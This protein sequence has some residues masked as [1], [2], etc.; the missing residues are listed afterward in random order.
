MKGII[1]CHSNTTNLALFG[2]KIALHRFN[3]RGL[4]LIIQRILKFNVNFYV[5]EPVRR[6]R[7]SRAAPILW[8]FCHGE[9]SSV[10]LSSPRLTW[11]WVLQDHDTVISIDAVV[12]GKESLQESPEWE[13]RWCGGDTGRQC[14][15][16]S[17]SCDRECHLQNDDGGKMSSVV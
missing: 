6:Q 8:W 17:S 1:W 13:Q 9:F 12:A 4:I 10:Q 11:C 14:V 7:R 15:P 3:H 16:R 5:Y 2:Y